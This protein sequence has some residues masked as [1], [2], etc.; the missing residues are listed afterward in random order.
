MDGGVCL[1]WKNSESSPFP[2]YISTCKSVWLSS[3]RIDPILSFFL[4]RIFL[5]SF[6]RFFLATKF[7]YFRFLDTIHIIF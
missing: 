2:S 7:F 6:F 4:S 5:L 3:A 1:G